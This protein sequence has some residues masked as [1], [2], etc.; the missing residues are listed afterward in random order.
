MAAK[1][2]KTPVSMESMFNAEVDLLEEDYEW[3]V[4]PGLSTRSRT[5]TTTRTKDQ[6]VGLSVPTM[7]MQ[8]T[9]EVSSWLQPGS[10]EVLKRNF[11]SIAVDVNG[12][13][14]ERTGT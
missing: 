12:K 8:T 10:S 2:N 6:T 14:E 13:R 7:I 11:V 3:T 1:R 4:T 5:S 9:C